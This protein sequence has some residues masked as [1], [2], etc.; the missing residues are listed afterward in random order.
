VND[1]T[2]PGSDPE[3]EVGLTRAAAEVPLAWSVDDGGDE[4]VPYT[5]DGDAETDVWSDQ[6]DR[7]YSWHTVGMFAALVGVAVLAAS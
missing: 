7:R 2:A 3:T 6:D 5:D 1:D 4:T